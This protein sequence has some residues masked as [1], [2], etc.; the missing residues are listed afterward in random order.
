M[1]S[2][3][4]KRV[5]VVGLGR[6]GGGV[7]V[8]RWLC[9]QGA[10]VTVS[11][12]AG[13]DSL[14]D[15][16][17]QLEGLDVTLHL[18][19]HDEADFLDA[20]L[21]V[22]N[23]AIPRDMPLLAA[24]D[25]AGVERTTEINLFMERCP[26]AMVGITGSVGKS[27]TTAMTGAILAP[28]RKTYVGG[29]IGGSLLDS[30]ADMTAADV[31]VLE[32]SSFQLED[33]PRIS[34]SPHVV[35]VTNLH[36]NHLDRHGTM[37]A[38][39][40]AKQNIFAFQQ[41]GDVLILNEA[42]P[43]TRDWA[44]LARGR[45]EYF[46]PAG[47]PFELSV[48]GPHNQ[49]NAQAAAAI[50]RQFGIDRDAASASLREFGGLEHRLQHVAQRGGVDFYNDSK[51]TTPEG[52]IVA[53][54][55]FDPGTSVVIVGGYDKGVPFEEMGRVLAGR[56]RAV[57]AI[58]A[59]A[60]SILAAVRNAAADQSPAV[61]HADSLAEAVAWAARQARPGDA[62][63]LSPGCASYDMFANFQQRGQRFCELV[64]DLPDPSDT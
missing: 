34:Q 22:V 1:S 23:P 55:A 20:E 18:G 53:A 60:E 36:P 33:L 4:G 45:V 40:A 2:L 7:G 42:D 58:G 21:L 48:P 41:A 11:D 15:S 46:S 52:V 62:V 29:N 56:A 10:D 8:T 43:R 47:E 13:A 6:F 5:T 19:S 51:C 27:T 32:L 17:A 39:A 35:C 30:L 26:A 49:A 54:N 28:R 59:T 25:H 14:T 37:E 64:R 57:V 31:V 63:L 61:H 3:S 50:A 38:Y 24:A 12:A 44:R 16:V 9:G